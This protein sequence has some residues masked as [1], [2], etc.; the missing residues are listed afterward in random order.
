MD[1]NRLAKIA[2]D[3]ETLPGYLNVLQNQENRYTG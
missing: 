2:K 3:E 1:D